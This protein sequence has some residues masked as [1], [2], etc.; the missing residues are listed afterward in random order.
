MPP[1]SNH[2][3]SPGQI[4]RIDLFRLPLR[5]ACGSG[6]AADGQLVKLTSCSPLGVI[7]IRSLMAVLDDLHLAAS[8]S[9]NHRTFLT[10]G[11]VVGHENPAADG[12]LLA[13]FPAATSWRA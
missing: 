10:D 6:V 1:Q 8:P 13:G 4:G 9:P 5:I 3:A 2:A 7:P 12:Q 11:A